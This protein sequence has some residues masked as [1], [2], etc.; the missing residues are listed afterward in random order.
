[1]WCWQDVEAVPMPDGQLCLLA[2]PPECCEGEGPEA[3]RYLKLFCRYIT[4]RKV[5]VNST[6]IWSQISTPLD[7]CRLTSTLCVSVRALF[8]VSCW[9]RPIR[10]SL[11]RVRRT[12]WWRNTAVKNTSCRAL[13][14]IWRL[15]PSSLTSHMFTSTRPSRGQQWF[16]LR[17]S[18]T[19]SKITWKVDTSVF[20]FICY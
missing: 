20:L 7:I 4:D 9:W 11:T 18:H 1:M 17:K 2:L 13:L 10:S 19:H 12:L 6:F 14:T 5:G 15:S 3:M 16:T 8:Q